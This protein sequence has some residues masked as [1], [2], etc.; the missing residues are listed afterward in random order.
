MRLGYAF[1]VAS[2]VT[3]GAFAQCPTPVQPVHDIIADSYYDDPPVYSHID[4]AR[5]AAYE[6]AVEPIETNLG[7]IA[8]MA[9]AGDSTCTLQWLQSWAG[10][11]AMLG[12]IEKEQAHYER[13]WVLAGLALS[14]AKVRAA[15]NAQTR[16]KID[17]WLQSLADG[18]KAHSDAYKGVR[19]NHYYWEG[20]AVAATGAVTGNKADLDWGRHVFDFAMNEIND[21]GT[22]PREMAR[23]TRALHYHFFSAEPLVMLASIL[24]VHSEKLDKL[25]AFCRTGR[26]DPDMVAARAGIVQLVPGAGAED[27]FLIYDRQRVWVPEN[28]LHQV[29]FNKRLGGDLGLA[30]PLEHPVN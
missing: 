11:G 2:L 5:H 3:G 27:A 26:K 1:A 13:K 10:G 12:K 29:P 17:N 30:N 18:V 8:K 16:D 7:G 28:P 24:D 20:L 19:N 22:L 4:P 15:A 21:D 14:Y 23:G 25:V 9:S 6:A